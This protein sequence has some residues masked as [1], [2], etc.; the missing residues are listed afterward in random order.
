MSEQGFDHDDARGNRCRICRRPF[1]HHDLD[2]DILRNLGACES[3]AL[4]EDD[5]ERERRAE[6]E[7]E[8]DDDDDYDYDEDRTP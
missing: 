5:H 3:C 4:D 1:D 6:L 7:G 2:E 8:Y